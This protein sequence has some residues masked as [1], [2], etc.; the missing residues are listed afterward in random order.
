MTKVERSSGN[1]YA[2]LGIHDADRMLVKAQLAVKI[3]EIINTR[4]WTQQE[5]ASALDM[6]HP[7]LSKMLRGQFRGVSEAKMVEL[8]ARLMRQAMDG[9]R[10]SL[11]DLLLADS[12]RVDLDLPKRGRRP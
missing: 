1:V 8:L 3:G 11:K 5:A 6:A 2:D 9:A 7:E 10:P 12:P 4:G